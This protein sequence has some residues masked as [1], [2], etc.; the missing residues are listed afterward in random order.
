[1]PKPKEGYNIDMS[2]P[3]YKEQQKKKRRKTT[4]SKSLYKAICKSLNKE[5]SKAI[6]DGSHVELPASLGILKVIKRKTNPDN[7]R[8]D[9]DATKKLGQTIYHLNLHSEGW[10]GS[11]KWIRFTSKIGRSFHYIFKPTDSNKSTVAKNFH[12]HGGHKKYTT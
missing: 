10:Y 11:W 5:I 1:M 12:K 6:I 4:H 3:F 8:V 9:F 7:L 2:Y